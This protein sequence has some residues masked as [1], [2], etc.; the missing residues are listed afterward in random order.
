MI[1]LIGG[2]PRTGKTTLS[3]MILKRDR[4]SCLSTD[5]IRNLLDFSPTKLG[6]LDLEYNKRPEYF[7]PYFLQFLK[8]L[9][10][11]GTDIILEGD[12]FTPEQLDSIK[13]RID[14]KCCFLGFS[15]VKLEDLKKGD[16][17]TDWVSRKSQEEQDKIPGNLVKISNKTKEECSKYN[18]QYF[19]VSIDR[20]GTLEKVYHY[21]MK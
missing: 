15:S 2:A 14:F 1:Y 6:I 19:D 16:P 8:I 12:I 7:F 17:Q 13:D 20:E 10:N 4:I 5:M 3:N 18:F 21:L 9:Q 11:R